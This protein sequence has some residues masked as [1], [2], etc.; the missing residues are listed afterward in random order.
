MGRKQ[1]LK[2][3]ALTEVNGHILEFASESASSETDWEFFCEC[4][5]ADC[6][7]MVRLTVNEYTGLRDADGAMLAPQHEL[8][9]EARAKRLRAG[10]QAL[11]EYQVR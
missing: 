1:A 10:T 9:G 7:A 6:H 4:G 11:R 3:A 2:T 8:S 5:E